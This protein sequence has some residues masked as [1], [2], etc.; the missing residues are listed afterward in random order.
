MFDSFGSDQALAE[1]IESY[2]HLDKDYIHESH[3]PFN[4][5]GM[6][7]EV[8]EENNLK[9][10]HRNVFFKSAVDFKTHNKA[11]DRINKRRGQTRKIDIDEFDVLIAEYFEWSTLKK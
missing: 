1:F 11:L 7:I 9:T 2:H 6:E 3:G 10:P 4:G 8:D 5:I